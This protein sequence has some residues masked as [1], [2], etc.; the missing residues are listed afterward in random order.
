MFFG[1]L[2]RADGLEKEMMLAC[3]ERRRKGGREKEDGGDSGGNGD[4]PGG[5]ERSSEESEHLEDAEYDGR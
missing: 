3:G 1:Y 4:G 5:A 2:M